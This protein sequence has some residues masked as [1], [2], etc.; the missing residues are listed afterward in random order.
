MLQKENNINDFDTFEKEYL[1]KNKEEIK[2]PV[3]QEETETLSKEELR[4]KLK[5]KLK[6]FRESKKG[7]I[8]RNGKQYMV[9]PGMEDLVNNTST[10]ITKLNQL[11]NK[12]KNDPYELKKFINSSM[13]PKEFFVK[14]FDKQF[15]KYPPPPNE[16]GPRNG[17]E[18]IDYLDSL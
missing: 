8:I 17:Q 12:F 4:K 1:E 11:M 16:E 10:D 2:I 14:L 9:N 13:M 6:S 18:L 5:D 15:K 7:P 3:E